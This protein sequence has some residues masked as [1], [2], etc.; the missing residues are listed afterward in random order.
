MPTR[1]QRS[2]ADYE[3][4]VVGGG[5]AGMSAARTAARSGVRPL[6]IQQGRIGGECTF[7]GC[8]PSKVLLAGAA[9]GQT[10]TTA[11][12][13]MRASIETI[14]GRED[15]DVF[16]REGIDV[17]HGWATVLPGRQVDLDGTRLRPRQLVIA[18]GSRPAVPAVDGLDQVDYLTNEN[19]FDLASP[20]ASLAILGGGAIGC[21]LA[22]AF[23]QFG[24]K[25]T[26][27]EAQDRL[28]P[29]EEPEASAVIADALENL[30]VEVRVGR[31]V[32]KV[33]AIGADGVVRLHVDDHC[34]VDADRLLVAVGRQ[35]DSE[36]MGLGAAGVATDRGY[37]ITD[38]FLATTASGIWAAGDVTGR[39]QLTHAAN[40]MGRVAAAN[41]LSPRWR[42]RRF[43][44]AAIPSVT[45]TTPEVARVGMTEHEAAD[46][47]GRVAFLP[48]GEVDRAVV[49]G[50]TAGFV[51]L[52]AGPRRLLRNVG[53]G[54]IL[55]ATVVS[56]RAGEMIHEPALAMRTAM[57]TGRL[58]QTVHAY[59]TWS[60]ALQQAAA[61]FFFEIEGRHAR[62]ARHTAQA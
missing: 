3:L 44:T 21:E 47:G 49:G 35:A 7:T 50:Q 17:L 1:G 51:K 6:L 55:G 15:D 34:T 14:A 20:P 62:P 19:V 40:E 2:R 57:F 24:S 58:A 36:G 5:A 56:A 28:L 38:D 54:R 30:G 8:V 26:V 45:F 9:A 12:A 53:G 25:V 33:D 59:P 32:T 16:A 48:M 43:D 46:L 37:V 61:Q 29:R 13:A 52:I 18:T 11:A 22:Q 27:I 60:V 42:R 39:L 10:F 41:A 4:I 23:A 31:M